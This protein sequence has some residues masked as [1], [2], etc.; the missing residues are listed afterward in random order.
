MGESRAYNGP[1][2]SQLSS[3]EVKRCEAPGVIKDSELGTLLVNEMITASRSN[4]PVAA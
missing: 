1:C 2:P 3:Y 4:G